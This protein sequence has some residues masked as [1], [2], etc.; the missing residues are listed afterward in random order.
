MKQYRFIYSSPSLMSLHKQI[1]KT[2]NNNNTKYKKTNWKKIHLNNTSKSAI[3][4]Q[5]WREVKILKNTT[6]SGGV[7]E[8]TEFVLVFTNVAKRRLFGAKGVDRVNR[9]L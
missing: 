4:A 1:I 5:K 8:D 7:A 6:G 2:S 9:L 3:S